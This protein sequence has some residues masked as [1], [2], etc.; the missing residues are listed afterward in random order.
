MRSLEHPHV[1]KFIGVLYK[2]KRLNLITEYIRGGTLKDYIRDMVR[3][4]VCVCVCVTLAE[5]ND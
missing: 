5:M 4:C 1:L 3:C 2:E